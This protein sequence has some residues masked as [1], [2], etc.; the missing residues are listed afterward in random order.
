MISWRAFKS[1]QVAP[2]VPVRVDN[3][4]TLTSGFAPQIN[5]A[6]KDALVQELAATRV[7]LFKAQQS[8]TTKLVSANGHAHKNGNGSEAPVSPREAC[9]AG[10][11]AEGQ[12]L[13]AANEA[14]KALKCYETVLTLHPDHPEAFIKMGGCFEKLG[15]NDEAIASYDCAIAVDNSMTVAHLHKGGLYNRLARYEEATRCYE[16]ALVKPVDHSGETPTRQ[17]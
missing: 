14:E 1:P 6:V 17:S 11:L 4:A 3:S 9:I 7:E 8:A 15:R 2:Q 10:L 5:Q 12:S 16:K 13:L